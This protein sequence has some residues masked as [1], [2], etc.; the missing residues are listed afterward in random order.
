MKHTLEQIVETNNEMIKQGFKKYQIA[1]KLGFKGIP[2]DASSSLS[3]KLRKAESKGL[4]VIWPKDYVKPHV[5][6]NENGLSYIENYIPDPIVKQHMNLTHSIGKITTV[7][8]IG[9]GHVKDGD[10][11]LRRFRIAGEHQLANK[12]D[13]IVIIGDLATLDCLSAWDKDKRKNMEGKR[14]ASEI[15]YVNKAL[16]EL[17]APINEYNKIQRKNKEKQYKPHIVYLEGNHCDR[18]NRYFEY[19]PTFEDFVSIPKN[20]KLDE[21]GIE[22][23]PYREYY[24]IE[25]VKF[26]HVPHNSIKPISGS[27]L[28]VSIPKKCLQYCDHDVVFGHTHRFEMAHTTTSSGDRRTAISVGCLLHSEGEHYMSGKISDWWRGVVDLKIANGKIL[29]VQGTEISLLESM[30]K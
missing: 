21:R 27:G 8:V 19:D 3:K 18:L 11:E 26:T 24:D 30:Y 23:S 1:E 4:E 9:D 29:G 15:E 13:Y 22:W 17:T 2:D 12:P 6:A 25:G 20:L 28:T 5:V 7:G 10:T 16:D 14:Y